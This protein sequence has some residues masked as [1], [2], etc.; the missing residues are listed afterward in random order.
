MHHLLHCR[1]KARSTP[2]TTRRAVPGHRRTAYCWSHAGA[3]ADGGRSG[4]PGPGRLLPHTQV[5]AA[6]PRA[7]RR[8]ALPRPTT[9]SRPPAR[10][11]SLAPGPGRPPPSAPSL[12]LSRLAGGLLPPTR[13]FGGSTERQGRRR[14]LKVGRT[15]RTRSRVPVEGSG[16]GGGARMGR[17]RGGW[18]PGRGGG[19]THRCGKMAEKEEPGCPHGIM[20][21]RG[22]ARA[23]RRDLA[24]FDILSGRRPAPC[25]AVPIG[26][27]RAARFRGD[28]STRAPIATRTLPRGA[29]VCTQPL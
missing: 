5:S 14:G 8:A 10:P 13:R 3:A 2:H 21:R 27:N 15:A 18:R 4:H 24:R 16:G 7:P 12:H 9:R 20:G 11:R 6:K 19:P 28:A 23:A 17:R 1:A 26:E 29:P 25:S 22:V